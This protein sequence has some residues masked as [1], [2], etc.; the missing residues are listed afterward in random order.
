MDIRYVFEVPKAPA[1]ETLALSFPEWGV[2]RVDLNRPKKL[3][4]MNDKFWTEMR[5]C[6]EWISDQYDLLC[7][8]I[9]GG[10]SKAFTAGID[11]EMLKDFTQGK[12]PSRNALRMYPIVKKL[13]AAF[14]AI[15][16][17]RIPVIAA[18]HGACIGGGID[19]ITACDIRLSTRD[20]VFTIKEVDV[21]LAAD[22][23]TLQRMPKVVG[24]M[25]WVRELAYTGR[26]FDG[27][28]A[29]RHG[30]V[31]Q[32]YDSKAALIEGALAL[33]SKISK[34]SPIAV[35]GTKHI[36]NHAQ[37]HSIAEGLDYV[38]VWNSG[39]IQTSDIAVA[40]KAITS[41]NPSPVFS[42]L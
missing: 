27:A 30:L 28:E 42:K 17:C 5:Q 18:V 34:K 26:V 15:E 13:Q 36:L 8:V 14:T 29:V 10:E 35:A 33:A 39:M 3:N 37:N 25:G 7:C 1:Y 24:N 22:V 11:L 9:T 21:G 19:L 20:A 12:D 38:A 4:T 32:V 16:S 31:N 23:G 41:K 2:V 40:T 6:F